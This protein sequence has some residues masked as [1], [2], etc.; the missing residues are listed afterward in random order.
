MTELKIESGPEYV[1]PLT[2]KT[3]NPGR[4]SLFIQLEVG[5]SVRI[6]TDPTERKCFLSS[7]YGFNAKQKPKNGMRLEAGYDHENV[8]RVW[9]VK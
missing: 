5:Q 6:P 3:T 2:S 9:R 4:V 1:R 8:A 7:V